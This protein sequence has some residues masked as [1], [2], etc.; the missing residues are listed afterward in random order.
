MI[1]FL[2]IFFALTMLYASVSTRLET[3][4]RILAVQGFLLFVIIMVDFREHPGIHLGLTAAEALIFKGIA[5][6]IFLMRLIRRNEIYREV[7]PYV[8]NFFS[9][10]ISSFVLAAGFVVA[11]VMLKKA[12]D[13]RSLYFG[14]SVS[15][16]IISLFLIL[17]RKKIITHVM[18]F[19]ML[20]NGIFLLSLSVAK[21]MPIIVSLGVLLDI[22]VA[23]FLLGIFVNKIQSTFEDIH[24]D[25]LSNLKD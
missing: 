4:I 18:G 6:P 8:S 21:E 12:S 10:F 5:I 2:I 14:V 25:E 17:T 9:I 13:L 24:I 1:E 20:E 22:F 7:E 11:F 15:A 16:I 3:Y 23:I 19:C